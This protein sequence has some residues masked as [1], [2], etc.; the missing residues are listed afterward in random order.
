MDMTGRASTRTIYD[1]DGYDQ[2]G[3]SVEGVHQSDIRGLR[4][5]GDDE[6]YH[7][8]DHNRKGFD[9]EG[10]HLNGTLY[11][12]A[13]YDVDGYDQ[14]GFNKRGHYRGGIHPNEIRQDAPTKQAF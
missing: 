12:G 13:G 7:G 8:Y 6:E 11:D 9:R 14:A 10:L 1:E 5:F 4:A 2:D 3:N